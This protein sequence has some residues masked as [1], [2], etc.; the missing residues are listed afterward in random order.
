VFGL[1]GTKRGE[2]TANSGSVQQKLGPN[3]G[4]SAKSGGQSLSTEE[5]KAL[6]R[7][8]HPGM[9]LDDEIDEAIDEIDVT[10]LPLP[11]RRA[12][13]ERGIAA[14]RLEAWDSSW[15][16]AT[17]DRLTRDFAA[18]S[19]ESP[20]AL[21]KV[22]C[23]TSTCVATLSFQGDDV[24][25]DVYDTIV[26]R[27]IGLG[28]RLEMLPPEARARDAVVFLDC[29]KQRKADAKAVPM[30]AS[31]KGAIPTREGPAAVMHSDP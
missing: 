10:K 8:S 17:E 20:F 22:E 27:P 29:A 19:E 21:A 5:L 28:C 16:A 25:Q 1:L 26:S 7:R 30:V 6:I 31:V 12:R 14:H 24:G 18:V 23:R 3:E 15:G 9:D 4:A 2:P 11:E 13:L